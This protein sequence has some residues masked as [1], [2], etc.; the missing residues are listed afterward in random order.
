[1]SV[2]LELLTD[3]EI[4]AGLCA[5]Y[6]DT[7]E[8]G[9][10]THRVS[11]LDLPQG[12]TR[13]G[14]TAFVSA[15]CNA[16]DPEL[17]CCECHKP[18]IFAS[19][20]DY[21]QRKSWRLQQVCDACRR[22]Q[23]DRKVAEE[24]E[25]ERAKRSQIED[26]YGSQQ[27]G[28]RVYCEDLSFK[29]AV[30]LLAL[31]RF[32]A[33]EDL[34]II[35]PLERADGLL[36][37]TSSMSFDLLCLLHDNRRILVHPGSPTNAFTDDVRTFYPFRVAWWPPV[38]DNEDPGQFLAELE[39][40][41]RQGTWPDGWHDQSLAFWREVALH[42]CLQYAQVCMAEHGFEFSAGDKTKHVLDS[43]LEDYSPAQTY[44][45]IYRAVKD[46]AAYLVSSRVP[47]KQAANS[48]IGRVQRMA[49]RAKADGWDIKPYGRDRRAAESCIGH[50]LYR[51]ALRLGESGIT[52][53]PNHLLRD[54]SDDITIPVDSDTDD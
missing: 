21:Q 48:V 52:Y 9:Q 45:F 29:E 31:F 33:S 38:G 17:V 42:E 43:V 10:Y 23:A 50:V 8:D 1:M 20:S 7:D 54:Y 24:A 51:V 53:V 3:D 41:F 28:V 26:C 35:A 36:A 14:L 18:F 47:K 22:I 25:A 30:A 49:E 39:N 16:Y 11:D 40:I 2:E 6:W 32:A 19:R 5:R 13:Y 37:P 44:V 27:H 34:S 46:A 4:I 15:H 12:V